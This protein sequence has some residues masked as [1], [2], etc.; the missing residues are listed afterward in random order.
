MAHMDKKGPDGK[1]P[2]TGRGLGRCKAKKQAEWRLGDGMA[3]KR[4]SD[5]CGEGGGRRLKSGK[6]FENK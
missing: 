5:A 4:R 1:G 6:I 2:A 3:M